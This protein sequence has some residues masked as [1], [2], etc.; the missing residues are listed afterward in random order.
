MKRANQS[1]FQHKNINI[2]HNL[3][4]KSPQLDRKNYQ[5]IDIK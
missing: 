3:V 1:E 2:D 5:K 4:S